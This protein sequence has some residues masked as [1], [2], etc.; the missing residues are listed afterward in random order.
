MRAPASMPTRK[1]ITNIVA[2]VICL[3]L[4]GCASPLPQ[5]VSVP[6]AVSCL[7]ANVHALPAIST[8]AELATLQDYALVLRIAAERLDLLSYARQADAIIAACR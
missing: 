6:V 4:S 1:H 3:L 7:P 5:T 8:D 2:S